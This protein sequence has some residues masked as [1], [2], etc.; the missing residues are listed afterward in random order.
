MSV[1]SLKDLANGFRGVED[2]NA[3]TTVNAEQRVILTKA[4]VKVRKLGHGGGEVGI[5][6]LCAATPKLKDDTAE[7]EVTEEDTA[8]TKDPEGKGE[9]KDKK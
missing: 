6:A 1:Q 3:T 4:K 8:P 5:M 2:K 7:E 9:S